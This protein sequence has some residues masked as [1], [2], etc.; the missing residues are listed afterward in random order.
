M[1]DDVFDRDELEG[2]IGPGMPADVVIATGER[3]VAAYLTS[4]LVEAVRRAWR[5]E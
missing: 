5:E 4:P 3:T 2:R 1:P